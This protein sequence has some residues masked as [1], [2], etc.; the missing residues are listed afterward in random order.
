V[1]L[2]PF[3]NHNGGMIEFGPDQFLY[4]GMGDGGS[5]ND[6]GN[7]A[8]NINDLLGKILRIDVDQ[9]VGGVPYSSPADNP[10]FGVTAGRDEIYA[11]GMRNPFRFS[12]DRITGQL[13]AGDVGQNAREEVDIITRG[14]NYGWRVME[15]SI[16]NPGFGGG[17]CAP[18]GIAPVA[19]YAHSTGRCSITGGYVYRGS[20]FSLPF[21]AYVYG[22]F[23]TGEI[24]M[25]S[26]GSAGVLLDTALNISSFGED[27]AGEIYVVGLDGTINRISNPNPPPAVPAP[28][29]QS[30]GLIRHS[31]QEPFEPIRVKSNGKKYD[32]RVFGT[33][34]VLDSR[35]F[36][37]GRSVKTS[38]HSS[39]REG[40][41][42]TG[43][44]RRD[45]LSEPGAMVVQIINLDGAHSGPF[46]LQVVPN[47]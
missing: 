22:D 9:S 3:A 44:M 10:F 25:L 16:C 35:I 42:L 41:F 37:N 31:N 14:G 33:G 38:L 30:A 20:Q 32:I 26:G 27:E 18:I 12:F 6:P 13:F 29:I 1:I 34:F 7:R 15:G 40:L 47:E 24:F 2:Q 4:I 8:Q 36:I 21:G 11:I 17:V 5:A 46:I 45:M 19:E 43:R 23:C 39:S 28:V